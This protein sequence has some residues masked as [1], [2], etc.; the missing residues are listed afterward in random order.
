M[1]VSV[2][3][4]VRVRV[5][6]CVEY[7]EAPVVLLVAVVLALPAV[8]AA[9]LPVVAEALPYLVVMVIARAGQ[10]VS[11]MERAKKGEIEVKQHI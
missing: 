4:R 5:R 6:V 11:R 2:R 7:L 9:P 10:N 3:V 1:V 8:V